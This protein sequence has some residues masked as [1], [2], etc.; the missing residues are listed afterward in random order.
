MCRQFTL[1]FII[2]C[3]MY[4]QAQKASGKMK[5]ILTAYSFDTHYVSVDS[6]EIAYVKQGNSDENLLFI[7]GLSSNLEAWSNNISRL[8]ENY[9]CYALDLPGFGKSSKVDA[10]YTP[11]FYAKVVRRFMENQ[12][13]DHVI[14]VGHS[15]GGQ[16]ALKFTEL[17]PELV[18]KLILIAPAGIETFSGQEAQFLKNAF[19]E[20]FVKSTSEAQIE[21][22]YALNF[23]KAPK[24]VEIMIE[25]RKNIREASDFYQHVQAIV[26]SVHGMLDEPVFDDLKAISK[27]TL[28]IFG[29][30]DYLIPNKYLHP[31]STTKEIG[32]LAIENIK[33][34]QLEMVDDAGHF[35]QFEKS[36][37]VNTLINSFLQEP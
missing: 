11:S 26:L 30:K 28:V 3:S 12:K 32:Q 23:Y 29:S 37:E 2:V 27:P 21:K 31:N 20:D 16:A 8:Q 5:D 19:T 10:P 14:L 34:A 35:V 13:L 6:M 1:C 33:E 17:Y 18:E 22:N 9:T 7:H 24:E 15:M 4:V 25:D 36:E